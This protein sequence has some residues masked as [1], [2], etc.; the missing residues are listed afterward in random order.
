M[1]FLFINP[2][3]K[4]LP[5]GVVLP[6]FYWR[7]TLSH[8][9]STESLSIDVASFSPTQEMLDAAEDLMATMGYIAAIKPLVLANQAA[10]LARYQWHIDPAYV[11]FGLP[12]QI[13]TDPERAHLLSPDD[14]VDYLEAVRAAHRKSGLELAHDGCPLAE[15]ESALRLSKFYLMSLMQPVTGI[16]GGELACRSVVA[17]EQAVAVTLGILAPAVDR[18]RRLKCLTIV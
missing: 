6:I 2:L 14:A 16:N 4:S 8:S 7:S 11:H 9:V 15:A 18:T 12:D 17:F 13:V 3:G 1:E 5:L 10:V